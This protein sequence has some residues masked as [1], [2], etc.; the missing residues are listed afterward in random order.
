M[1]H[2]K[3]VKS[4]RLLPLSEATAPAKAAHRWSTLDIIAPE[5]LK[6]FETWKLFLQGSPNTSMAFMTFRGEHIAVVGAG[7]SLFLNKLR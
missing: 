2:V 1:Q 3:R 6:I 7:G 5:W 4:S